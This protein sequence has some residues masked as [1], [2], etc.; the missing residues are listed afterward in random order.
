MRLEAPLFY[1][2]GIDFFKEFSYLDLNL[3]YD[4]GKLV[5]AFSIN[6]PLSFYDN[7]YSIE[8][9]LFGDNDLVNDLYFIHDLN[10]SIQT[11]ITYTF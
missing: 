2:N 9:E 8:S 6:N 3:S 5:L 7:G 10:F 1:E 11:T 4:I